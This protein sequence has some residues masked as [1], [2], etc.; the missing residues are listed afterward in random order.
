MSDEGFSINWESAR[1][2]ER[3]TLEELEKELEGDAG[4]QLLELQQENKVGEQEGARAVIDFAQY[5]IDRNVI[6]CTASARAANNY[7]QAK[8]GFSSIKID[9]SQQIKG[10]LKK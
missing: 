9:V 4:R 2:A 7:I 10:G 5:L 6:G 1:K 3:V 8:Y